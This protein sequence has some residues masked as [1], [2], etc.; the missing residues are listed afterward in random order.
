MSLIV[1]LLV[2]TLAAQCWTSPQQRN[3]T[4]QA[5]LYLTGAQGHRSVLQRPSREEG[6]TLHSVT[7]RDGP[8]LNVSSLFLELLLRAVEEAAGNPDNYPNEQQQN[9]NYL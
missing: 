4:P 1:T 6:D 2:V 5:I 8:G 3:W 9:L 7:H